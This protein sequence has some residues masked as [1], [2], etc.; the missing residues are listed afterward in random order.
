MWC[1]CVL[2]QSAATSFQRQA[3]G[4]SEHRLRTQCWAGAPTH[5]GSHPISRSCTTVPQR[6]HSCTTTPGNKQHSGAGGGPNQLPKLT[7]HPHTPPL[8]LRAP[9]LLQPA[10]LVPR[11]YPEKQQMQDCSLY[12]LHLA[13]WGDENE[14]AGP[15]PRVLRSTSVLMLAMTSTGYCLPL[16]EGRQN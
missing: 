5:G 14:P 15:L 16:M 9:S 1:I 3:A 11:N 4:S 7:Y 13:G 12:L 2:P 8:S 10:L 6:G